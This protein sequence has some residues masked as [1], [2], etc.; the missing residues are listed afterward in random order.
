MCTI[1]LLTCL[2]NLQKST[3]GYLD[4]QIISFI[5]IPVNKSNKP[6]QSI[7]F[8]MSFQF[9][10]HFVGQVSPSAICIYKFS[11]DACL[12]V[13][14]RVD[15]HQTSAIIYDTTKIHTHNYDNLTSW[16]TSWTYIT[17]Y[18]LLHEQR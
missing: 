11:P 16:K 17:E 4:L 5:N 13:D 18:S 9:F 10:C 2:T 14:L 15:R 12:E 8:W 6:S 3:F 1:F 7:L